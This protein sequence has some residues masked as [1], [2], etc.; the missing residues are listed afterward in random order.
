[1]PTF[2]LP[3]LLAVASSDAPL[4]NSK[5]SDARAAVNATQPATDGA[6]AGRKPAPVL[7]ET[8]VVTATRSER[9]VSELPVSTTVISEREIEAAPVLA[10]ADSPR[11]R[12][13]S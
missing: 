9:N 5:H 10:T 4:N 7:N 8:M 3:L 6:E 13:A 1:M 12:L 2:C 11:E